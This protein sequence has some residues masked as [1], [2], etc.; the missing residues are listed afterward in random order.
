M[1]VE[2]VGQ[3]G[4]VYVHVVSKEGRGVVITLPS[5]FSISP[6]LMH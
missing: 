2:V 1:V 5:P 3:E 4:G 6:T